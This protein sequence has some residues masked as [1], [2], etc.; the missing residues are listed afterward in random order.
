MKMDE[1]LR[2]VLFCIGLM[3]VCFGLGMADPHGAGA[4]VAAPGGL[5]LGVAFPFPAK[6]D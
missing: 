2:R 3:L 6:G 4:I 5:L 1:T